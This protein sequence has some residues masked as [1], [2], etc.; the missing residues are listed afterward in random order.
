MG[1]M[2]F[3][4]R[5]GICVLAVKYTVD[6]GVWGDAEKAIAFKNQTCKTVNEIDFVQTGKAHFKAYVPVPEVRISFR[7]IQRAEVLMFTF[8][9]SFRCF[10][11]HQRSGLSPRTIITSQ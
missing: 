7:M 2:S 4:V 11:L 9:F 6:Q 10:R 3:A 5:S 8:L 1:L